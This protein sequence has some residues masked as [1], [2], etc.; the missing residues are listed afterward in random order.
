MIKVIFDEGKEQCS[1][2]T[3]RGLPAFETIRSLMVTA[4]K[5]L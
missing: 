3:K 4:Q 5:G 1:I 2:R